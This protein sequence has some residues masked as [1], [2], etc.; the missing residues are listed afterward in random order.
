VKN[1]NLLL[2]IFFSAQLCIGQ[3][4]VIEG[5]LYKSNSS[6]ALPYIA[7]GIKGTSKGT[8]TDLNGKFSIH[9]SLTDSLVFSCVGFHSRT[10]AVND[11]G[12]PFYL[13][14][15]VTQLNEVVFNSKRALRKGLVGNT[16]TKTVYLFGGS[17]QYACLLKNDLKDT[18][19]L[20]ELYFNIQPDRNKENQHETAIRIRLYANEGN[21]PGKDLTTEDIIFKINKKARILAIDVSKQLI[22]L[23]PE[24]VFV[25]LDLLGVYNQQGEFI[26]YNR[27]QTPLN[28]RIEFSEGDSNLTYKK[29]FGTG[30][31]M[32]TAKNR[33]GDNVKVSA[34]FGAK[35]IY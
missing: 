18:G 5:V 1:V 21:Q 11:F 15:K 32:V 13:T 30:W 31:S 25:G 24:G 19:I 28:L 10:I 16:R 35:V 9:T 8:V 22:E 20:E 27:N 29:F 34:K 12:S 23:P 4:Q 7:I 3:T 33:N 26:P 6:E 14:E 2:L 17:N